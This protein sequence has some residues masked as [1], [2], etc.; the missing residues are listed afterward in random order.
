MW[1]IDFNSKMKISDYLVIFYFNTI[2]SIGFASYPILP[3]AY[4]NLPA[5]P[6]ILPQ[7]YRNYFSFDGDTADLIRSIVG[8]NIVPETLLNCFF[9]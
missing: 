2:F 8:P 5:Q 9:F 6:L 1:R 4:P 3:A 7:P